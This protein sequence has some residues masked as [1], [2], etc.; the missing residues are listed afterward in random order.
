MKLEMD[1][2]NKYMLITFYH[3]WFLFYV[4]L[5]TCIKLRGAEYW[6]E[7]FGSMSIQ[8]EKFYSK[9]KINTKRYRFHV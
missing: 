9:L 5:K 1:L 4:Y 6:N 8:K 2:V 7:E 3:L